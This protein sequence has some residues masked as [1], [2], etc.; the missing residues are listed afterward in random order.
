[1]KRSVFAVATALTVASATA[2]AQAVQPFHV[3]VAAGATLPM[4]DVIKSTNGD[5]AF[6][7]EVG[8]HVTGLAEFSVPVFPFGVRAEVM[9]HDLKG[10]SQ[11]FS[12]PT[13]GTVSA[14]IDSRVIAGT[15]NALFTGGGM[16][17]KPYVIGGV[18]VYNQQA[19]GKVS[20]STFGSNSEKQKDT[21]FGLNGGL[22]FRFPLGGMSTF[23]EARYHYIFNKKD[24]TNST[25]NFCTDR[26][27]TS[28]VPIS[29]GILF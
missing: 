15:L 11:T 3:G 2:G 18:G 14:Q 20:S 29:F 10:K 9:Y 26:D 16:M 4:S 21:N 7:S 13:F 27:N 23:A 5:P 6:K 22:G 12:D 1:M 19:T 28:I 17:A 25:A 24:C 8:Y